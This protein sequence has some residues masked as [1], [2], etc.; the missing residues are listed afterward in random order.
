MTAPCPCCA[1]Q[2]TRHVF[3]THPMPVNSC[4]L[5]SSR[6]TSLDF[7]KAVLTIMA[8]DTCGFLW[9]ATFDGDRT[10]YN[11]AYEATQ[12]HS[13]HFRKYLEN[14]AE[15]WVKTSDRDV[16]EVGCGMGEFL[17]VLKGKCDARLSG[18]DPAFRGK[19]P[20]G[21]SITATKLP[22]TAQQKFDTVINR[23]TLE[24]I[25]NPVSF[26]AA[27]GDWLR[28]DGRLITQVPNSA[29]MLRDG[30]VCDLFYEHVNYFTQ[31]SL[32][33]ALLAAGFGDITFETSYDDQHLTAFARRSGARSLPRQVAI[34]TA[35]LESALK[36]FHPDW[37]SRLDDQIAK[38][39]T[40]WIWGTGSRATTFMAMLGDDARLK[41]AIDINP[42]RA[43]SYILGT[44]C[45]T[46]MPD[47]L[48]G[49]RNLAIIVM[50]PI[51][52][53]EIRT[54]LADLDANAKLL[55]LGENSQ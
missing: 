47:V 17:T 22:E 4:I 54:A 35:P 40:I 12:I 43:G 26:L 6:K 16:L 53:P 44:D 9:N 36:R 34:P 28:E 24:H 2:N 39:R 30:L 32:G 18:F 37:R 14:T 51:Y 23:M 41:G 20:D 49:R 31:S 42:N 27:M 38:G 19:T 3:T 33:A 10:D 15:G 48:R 46:H 1:A 7:A 13:P 8:C 52:E 45:K 25:Q 5:T 29:R 21:V 50:N 55:L 11:D